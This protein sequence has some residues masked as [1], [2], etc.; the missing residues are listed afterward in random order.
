[1]ESSKKLLLYYPSYNNVI[2]LRVRRRIRSSNISVRGN[3]YHSSYADA[4]RVTGQYCG[5]KLMLSSMVLGEV[6]E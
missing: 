2:L 4:S 1:M 6:L 5:I 3:R